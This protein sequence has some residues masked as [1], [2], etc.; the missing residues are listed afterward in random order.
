MHP[1]VRKAAMTFNT[2]FQSCTGAGCG[3][4]LVILGSIGIGL[5]YFT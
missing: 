4:L 5:I 1:E 3:C 2:L